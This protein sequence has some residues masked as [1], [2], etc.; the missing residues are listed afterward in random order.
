MQVYL[1]FQLQLESLRFSGHCWRSKNEAGFAGIKAWQNEFLLEADTRIPRDCLL[2]VMAD[3]VG[4]R[5]KAIGAE[6]VGGGLRL[7]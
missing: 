4:W 2:T 6:R 7:T 1:R 5:K 3:R